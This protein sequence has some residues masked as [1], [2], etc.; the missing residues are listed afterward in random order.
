MSFSVICGLIQ[1]EQPGVG[2]VKRIWRF[3]EAKAS[4]ERQ[5]PEAALGITP[6]ADARGPAHPPLAL[7]P[8]PAS[9]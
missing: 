7:Q 2:S 3:V 4:R 6:V 1:L 5:R 8:S 9:V